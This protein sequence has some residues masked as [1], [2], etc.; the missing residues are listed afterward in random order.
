MFSANYKK[1]TTKYEDYILFELT[2]TNV[3]NKLGKDASTSQTF[4]CTDYF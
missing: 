2:K 3:S 1:S 4:N